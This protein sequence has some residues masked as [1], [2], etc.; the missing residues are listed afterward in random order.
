[1][2]AQITIRF[3]VPA[4][5]RPGDYARL[6]GDGGS[7]EID[8]DAPLDNFDSQL[9]ADG[10]ICGFGLAPFGR[11]RF[12]RAHSDSS[13]G[14]GRLPFGR[15]PFGHGTSVLCFRAEVD[16]CGDYLF[17]LACYDEAGN[18]H[19]GSPEELE[20]PVHIAPPAPTGLVKSSYDKTT[21]VL[22]LTVAA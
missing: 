22:I 9:F 10:G 20:V 1:M 7:G 17:A 11:H 18:V 12:G 16:Y 4:G 14:F 3:V 21:D 15:Y 2:V 6:H 5:Y 13:S 8:W 19:S